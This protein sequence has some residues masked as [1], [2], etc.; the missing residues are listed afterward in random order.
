MNDINV[1][2]NP[3]GQVIQVNVT[4]GGVHNDHTLL[5][6]IGTHTHEE[7]DEFIDNGSLVPTGVLLPFGG[8]SAPD[9]FLI[10]DGSAV[11]RSTYAALFAVIGTKYGGGDGST[12]FNLPNVKG[13]VVIGVDGAD[14][15]FNDVGLTGGAKSVNLQ[16]SHTVNSHSHT[17]N[18]HTHSTPAHNHVV[19][20]T[21][22]NSGD[23]FRA[24]NGAQFVAG[25]NV[26]LGSTAGLTRDGAAPP[27]SSSIRTD[28]S[29]SGTSGSTSPGTDSQTPGTNNGLSTTQSVLNPFVTAHYIIKT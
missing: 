25:S 24:D 28:T 16:H 27:T 10:C 19:F 7:I 2:L 23:W 11:S 29:G 8:T 26:Q 13:K 9:G 5:T 6:N 4:L 1:T 18:S 21:G 22:S 3:A 12:T 17:V 14:G 15:T 20:T